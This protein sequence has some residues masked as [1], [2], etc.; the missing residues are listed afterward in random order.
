MAERYTS[1]IAL[2]LDSP[3]EDVG[4]VVA[5]AVKAGDVDRHAPVGDG[6]EAQ[7]VNWGGRMAKAVVRQLVDDDGS[8]LLR[9]EAYIGNEGLVQGMTRQAQ[10]VQGLARQLSGQVAGVR[11]LSAMADRDVAWINRLAIGAVERHDAIRTVDAGP[12]THWVHTYGAARLDVPDLELYGMAKSQV[13]AAEDAIAHVQ[14]TLLERGLKTQLALPTGEPVY[15]VPVLD[16]WQHLPQDWPGVGR[17]GQDRGP[18]R[19]TGNPVDPAQAAAGSVPQGLQGRARRA[20]RHVTTAEE[21]T[22]APMPPTASGRSHGRAWMGLDVPTWLGVAGATLLA[23]VLRLVA[24]GR[25]LPQL[26]EPDE[27]T[28]VDRAMNV[29]EGMP[30]PPIW[31]WPPGGAAIDAVVLTLGDWLGAPTLTDPATAYLWSRVAF[32]LLGVLLVPATAVLAGQLSGVGRARRV[33]AVGAALTMAV[34]FL[35]VRFARQVHPDPLQSLFIVF[36]LLA[37]LRARR[38]GLG[39][40]GMAGAMAGAAAAMKFI[41]G[42]VLV[43]IVVYALVVPSTWNG[44]VRTAA[45]A[46]GGAATAFVVATLGTAITDIRG[47]VEGIS[48]QFGM[49]T[50]PRLGYEGTEPVVAWFWGDV[51]PGSL[52]WPVMLGSVAGL[53]WLVIRRRIGDSVLVGAAVVLL[54][55]PLLSSVRFP[56]YALPA[57]PLLAVAAMVAL[58]DLSTAGLPALRA[59]AGALA[60]VGAVGLWLPLSGDLGLVAAARGIDTRE[61][62]TTWLAGRDDASVRVWGEDYA[63]AHTPDVRAVNA[64]RTDWRGCGCLYVISSYN[65]D[66]YRRDPITYADEVATYDALHEAGTVVASFEPS[67]PLS[68][69]WNLLPQWGVGALWR[70]DPTS[71]ETLVTG[72]LVTVLRIESDTP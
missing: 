22:V 35:L 64:T 50:G 16:A 20:A 5:P 28:T 2:V 60:V 61:Q 51:L 68:Y 56:H 30:A 72:P 15:L 59:T 26:V 11:D 57:L 71:D 49:Q 1:R 9:T 45:L 24:I 42:L 37:V 34:S 27:P 17:A 8:P 47:L 58:G 65:E 29:L 4:E 36:A 7:E 55:F 52:G 62:A 67:I 69:R 38:G 6:R 12:G 14:T 48:W 70:G 39:W 23:G 32:A 66:R 21:R 18:G 63:L 33:A 40:W 25:H 31:D 10:L 46:V 43:P 53:V 13:P 3:V 54:A 41:G 44:R 19:T